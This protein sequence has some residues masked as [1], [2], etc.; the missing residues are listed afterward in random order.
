M[1]YVNS[2][3]IQEEINAE[4]RIDI[5]WVTTRD[6]GKRGRKQAGMAGSVSSLHGLISTEKGA[7]DFKG[8]C[9]CPGLRIKTKGMGLVL[10][11]GSELFLNS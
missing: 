6:Q 9:V 8:I 1:R 11:T 2:G 4:T 10:V 3:S 7:V 5:Q